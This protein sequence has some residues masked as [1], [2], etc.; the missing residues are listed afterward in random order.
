MPI[1]LLDCTGPASTSV[2]FAFRLQKNDIMELIHVVSDTE[3]DPQIEALPRFWYA[4][5]TTFDTYM[6]CW[7][8]SELV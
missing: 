3:G 4:K 6:M 2:D 1:S 5:I 8:C 7:G